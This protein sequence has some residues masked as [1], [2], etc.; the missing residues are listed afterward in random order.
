[1]FILASKSPRRIEIL[2]EN[3]YDFKVFSSSVEE[4]VNKDVTPDNNAVSIAL[5]KALD[6]FKEHQ[7]EVVVAADTIVVLDDVILGKPI[8]EADAFNMLKKLSNRTHQVITAVAIVN[9]N[10]QITFYEESLVTFNN[11]TDEEIDE[12]IKTKEPMDKAGSYGIQGIGQRLVK[13][14]K[15]DY[16]NIMGLPINMF[17]SKIKEVL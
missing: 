5:S 13:S 9:K 12:Y 7:N 17:N 3:N 16:Y 11:L 1:M 6:V 15:G 14:Y 4:I 10:K 2:K 8:D